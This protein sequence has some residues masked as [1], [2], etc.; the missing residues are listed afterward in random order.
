MKGYPD[1][2]PAP[3]DVVAVPGSAPIPVTQSIPEYGVVVLCDA[4]DPEE[5]LRENRMTHAIM[6][7][8]DG[9]HV[10][11]YDPEGNL[12]R[13]GKHILSHIEGTKPGKRMYKIHEP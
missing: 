13:P 12:N 9:Q 5:A 7:H 8:N 2:Y 6:P 3:G 11:V 1:G 4:D 10:Q